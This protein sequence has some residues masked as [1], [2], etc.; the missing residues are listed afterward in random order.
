MS[1]DDL[2]QRILSEP[3]PDDLWQLHPY[4][5]ALDTPG[6]VPARELTRMFYC[7]LSCV[8]SKLTSKQYSTLAAWLAAGS[9][10]V[11]S[12]KDVI[13]AA[14]SDW[15][16]LIGNLLAGGLAGSLELLSTRQHVKAWQTE[17]MS[18]HEE[19]VWHLYAMLWQLSV[20]AQ[21]DLAAEKRQALID[22]LLTAV[23]NPQLDG[24]ARMAVIIRLFQVLLVIRLA[25]LF[26]SMQS[27]HPSAEQQT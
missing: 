21:P 8:R 17:F 11:I 27:P 16:G 6:A 23:R 4:L 1:V 10:G 9:I 14:P 3:S 20:E 13:E 5:L 24:M 15:P 12:L 2:L 19:A 26:K 25:P 7:Y 18:V 22:P